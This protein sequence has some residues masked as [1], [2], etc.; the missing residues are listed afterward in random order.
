MVKH[1][2]VL[3]HILR[4]VRGIVDYRLV[5]TIESNGNFLS[6]FL[7][8]DLQGDGIDRMSTGGMCF[9]LN[10]SLISW[11]SQ[12]ERVVPLSSCEAEYMAAIGS[13]P[14]HLASWISLRNYKATFGISCAPCG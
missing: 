6:G 13:V 7:D 12:K 1:Q 2:Q 4:Y 10:K 5:Y 9:Y 3:K 11:A 14:K 8:N